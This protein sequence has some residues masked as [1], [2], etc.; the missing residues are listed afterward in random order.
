L[1]KTWKLPAAYSHGNLPITFHLSP[2]ASGF[3]GVCQQT[4]GVSKAAEGNLSS[5]EEK[6][7]DVFSITDLGRLL[8]DRLF[9]KLS[10]ATRPGGDTAEFHADGF[11]REVKVRGDW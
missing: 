3:H 4:L 1:R 5:H 2:I 11:G 10:L 6:R 9:R 7:I 8:P